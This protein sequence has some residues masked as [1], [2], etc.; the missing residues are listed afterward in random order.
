MNSITLNLIFQVA[1]LKRVN[2]FVNDQD[3]YAR[4]FI[5]I[6]VKKYSH[7][8]EQLLEEQATHSDDGSSNRDSNKQHTR[9]N[10]QR[11][12]SLESLDAKSASDRM[13]SP[14]ASGFFEKLDNHVTLVKSSVQKTESGFQA[15]R[16]QQPSTSSAA[17]AYYENG[18]A[19]RLIV[20]TGSGINQPE[21]LIHLPN[22]ANK[23]WWGSIRHF[24]I[25]VTVVVI[26]I[27]L[28]IGL[29]LYLAG[30]IKS[31]DLDNSEIHLT[32]TPAEKSRN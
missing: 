15:A 22:Y 5:K 25:M 4:L 14:T 27:L 18:P 10:S 11:S 23:H 2:S 13:S 7:L 21:D 6:P 8:E 31:V 26:V 30:D 32:S 24:I 3:F 29:V 16:Q 9:L 19:D 28:I 17:F 1:D 12:H 20:E